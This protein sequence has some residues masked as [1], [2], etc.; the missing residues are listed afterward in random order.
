MKSILR[1][2]IV[3]A[4]LLFSA[5][6]LFAQMDVIQLESEARDQFEWY[7]RNTANKDVLAKSA[8]LIDEAERM[9]GAFAVVRVFQ[10][11][12]KIYYRVAEHDLNP[13][14]DGKTTGT[15]HKLR[16]QAALDAYK[17]LRNCLSLLTDQY[18]IQETNF[19]IKTLMPLLMY[20]GLFAYEATQ[21]EDAY[22]MGM[23]GD[24]AFE[25]LISAGFETGFDDGEIR[26]SLIFVGGAGALQTA[27]F[28]EAYR[29]LTKA[30]N[31]GYKTASEFEML[32]TVSMIYD[33]DRG[34]L[35]WEEACEAFPEVYYDFLLA[36]INGAAL[37]GR[38]DEAMLSWLEEAIKI[39]PQNS[40]LYL[41][42]G[43][44]FESLFNIAYN[45]PDGLEEAHKKFTAALADYEKALKIDPS[46]SSAAYSAAAI[47]F[48]RASMAGNINAQFP[49]P[50]AR[51]TE[52]FQ[53][54]MT[55][56]LIHFMK[57]EKLN[58]N[59]VNILAALQSIFE[60][61]G[62]TRKAE[63]IKARLAILDEG[64]KLEKPYFK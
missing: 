10:T 26:K 11:K 42:R 2:A 59:D 55:E 40:S 19:A 30:Y 62:D 52:E 32:I 14:I 36:K 21:F 17:A 25:A 29:L 50:D 34:V 8:D 35:L 12:A 18:S 24:E 49:V 13:L 43:G 44:C 9:M 20:E 6:S 64:G 16:P 54:Y 1:S 56:S 33:Y 39:D 31:L 48:N 60:Y 57:A 46:N 53:T 47:R 45:T 5:P 41:F 63:D 15:G 23:A 58:P 4:I 28:E 27:R 51:Y 38:V 22:A 61:Q 7:L 3:G 37:A